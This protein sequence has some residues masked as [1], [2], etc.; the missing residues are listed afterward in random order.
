MKK[1]FE[2]LLGLGLGCA[3]CTHA[4]T[5]PAGA[6]IVDNPSAEL[7]GAWQTSNASA[8]KYGS[9]YSWVST[10]DGQ[11]PTATAIFR[12]RI[13][14]AGKYD[15]E[16]MYPAG[17]NRSRDS[18]WLVSYDGGKE[19]V[20]INQ[21]VRGGQWVLLA[22]EKPFA[23]GTAGFVQLSNNTGAGGSIIVADA[24][25]FIPVGGPPGV[26]DGFTLNV[27][28]AYGG[29]V[30]TSPNQSSFEKNSV[31]TL[32]A[33]A[34]EGYVFNGWSGDVTGWKNPVKVT[35]DKN[36][37]ITANFLAA[38][39]GVIMD[40]P[41]SEKEGKWSLS[42]TAWAGTW[43]DDYDFAMAKEKPEAYARYIPNIPK[44][45]KY[46]V[47][48][49]YAQGANRSTKVPWSVS[50]KG[51]VVNT[52][53]NQQVKGGEWVQIASGVEFDAG[54]HNRQYAE[55]NNGTGPEKPGTMIVADAVAFVYVGD[56]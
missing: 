3:L 15:I 40:N 17:E 7:D 43:Y 42:T 46:D 27:T 5:D 13:P 51:G 1:I 18:K 30:A 47:Y 12:P 31:V 4:Q 20:V 37:V 23:A 10:T 9:N 2:L 44:A 41:S 28:A 32:T 52:I 56:K 24:V 45:G 8:D 21:R 11:K 22:K 39:V 6:I 55:V 49:R 26:K 16:V 35:M 25:R 29:T 54:K 33:K 14:V 48:I 50:H 34:N 38:G 36:K 19:E 53:V